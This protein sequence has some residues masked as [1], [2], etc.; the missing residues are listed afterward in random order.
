MSEEHMEDESVG[1]V[2]KKILYVNRKA[3]HGTV[4]ALESLEVA[5]IGA[6]FDQDVS[7]LFEGDGVF[8]LLKNQDT[9]G[10]G[11]KN[12]SPTFRALEMYDIEKL[13]VEETSLQD[14][15]LSRDDLLVPVEVLT[16]NS[17][18]ELI[19]NQDVILSF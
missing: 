9:K 19:T 17:V 2:V 12:F 7:I 16:A 14:R 11:S 6:A 10:L 3:P 13:Y 15:G 4:F 5:L 8:E 18:R 1:G